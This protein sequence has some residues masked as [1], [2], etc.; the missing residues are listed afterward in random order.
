MRILVVDDDEISRTVLEH[1]LELGGYEVEQAKSGGDA[2]EI[3]RERPCRL[4]ISDWEMPGMDGT[5]LCRHIRREEFPGYVYVI[6]LTGRDRTADV[7][8]GLSAGADDFVTK[9]IDPNVLR[10][11]VRAAERVLALETR[12]VAIFALAKLAESREPETGA[13]LERVR[14]YSRLLA[15]RLASHPE[16]GADIDAEFVR[17]IYLTSPL[18]DIVPGRPVSEHGAGHCAVAPRAL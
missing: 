18:H 16:F 7:V 11:R 9:P 14:T 10:V 1:A 13:H 17:L 6:L 8:E 12:D 5:E 15:R 4:V 2:L 3:L